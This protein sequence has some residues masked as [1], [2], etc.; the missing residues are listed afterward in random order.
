MRR[1][2]PGCETQTDYIWSP[3]PG[4]R[5]FLFYDPDGALIQA[6]EDKNT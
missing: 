4:I 2:G 1:R 6:V 5:S 3:L